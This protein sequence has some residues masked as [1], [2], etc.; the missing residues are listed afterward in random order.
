MLQTPRKPHSQNSAAFSAFV[1]IATGHLVAT[2]LMDPLVT[3][4]Q[5]LSGGG[6]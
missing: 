2:V 1:L 3:V 5:N 4:I 6:L